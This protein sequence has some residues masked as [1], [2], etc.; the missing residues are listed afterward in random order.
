MHKITQEI[1]E[2]KINNKGF[3]FYNDFYRKMSEKYYLIDTNGYLYYTKLNGLCYDNGTP[4]PFHKNNI[5][6]IENIKHYIYLNNIDCELI[7]GE[8]VDAHSLLQFK[9][10]CGEIFNKSWS[11]FISGQTRCNKCAEELVQKHK[12]YTKEYVLEL[13]KNK[14]YKMIEDSFTTMSDGFDAITED[15]YLLRVHRGN[16]SLNSTPEIFHPLN[17]YTIKNINHYFELHYNGE[18]ICLEENY[19]NNSTQMRFLHV[20]CNKEFYTTFADM[21][22]RDIYHTGEKRKKLCPM[23]SSPKRE[24]YH[25]LV[26]KQVFIHEMEGTITEDKSCVNPTTNRSLPTDIVNHKNKIAIEIQS[27]YHDKSYQKFKDSIKQQ[28][29]I[30]RGYKFYALD[31]RDY[32]ILQMIQFFFPNITKIPEYI[33]FNYEETRQFEIAQQYIDAGYSRKK[34]AELLNISVTSL[35][36]WN[37]DGK[38]NLTTH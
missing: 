16:I 6:T 17:P 20:S 7:S 12:T 34:T 3:Y 9:C 35:Y 2:Q 36:Y 19:I 31:I 33:D 13:I 21:K 5:F 15:G 18:Y 32:S 10:K 25:A 24:S 14:P 26:L 38:I 28:Y 29:W 4:Q 22:L 8:Y 27:A 30:N 1:I 37:K 23:C 11:K